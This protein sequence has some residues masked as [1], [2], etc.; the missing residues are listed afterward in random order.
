MTRH[1]TSALALGLLVL[2]LSGCQ[3][4]VL[5]PARD[6]VLSNLNGSV[7]NVSSKQYHATQ[8]DNGKDFVMGDLIEHKEYTYSEEGMLLQERTFGADSTLLEEFNNTYETKGNVTTITSAA[9]S[10]EVTRDLDAGTRTRTFKDP[11]GNI[12][13]VFKSKIDP[14]G[15]PL[16]IDVFSPDGRMTRKS[17]WERDVRGHVTGHE[18]YVGDTLVYRVASTLNKSGDPTYEVETNATDTIASRAFLYNYDGKGNWI[19]RVTRHMPKNGK[20]YYT[21][22]ERAI[23]YY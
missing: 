2:S 11:K 23:T 3:Q 15:L 18:E 8:K 21:L 10:E 13:E 22:S 1:Y 20:N 4:D 12:L 5:Q 16:E 9:G 19:R 17:I 14:K 6:T 7:R